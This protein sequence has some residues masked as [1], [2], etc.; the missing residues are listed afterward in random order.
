[1][2][3]NVILLGSQPCEFNVNNLQCNLK[4]VRIML[5]LMVCVSLVCSNFTLLLDILSQDY[6]FR[7]LKNIFTE[8]W[9]NFSRAVTLLYFVH[10]VTSVCAGSMDCVIT[11]KR[12]RK[13]QRSMFVL[14]A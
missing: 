11:L 9:Q 7:T 12:K 6:F 4:R 1:M 13:C 2:N 14:S 10:S 3:L 5:F 8:M